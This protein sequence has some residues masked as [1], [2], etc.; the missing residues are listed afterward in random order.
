MCGSIAIT[1]MEKLDENYIC[2]CS[3]CRKNSGHLGQINSC[4][5]INKVMIDD[6]EK[7]LGEFLILNTSSGKPK[8]KEFCLRCG[9]TIRTRLDSLPGKCIVRLTLLDD[10]F[11]AFLPPEPLFLEEK[12]KFTKNIESEY[13]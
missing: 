8:H 10:G 11:P 9:C 12:L 13:F 5:D 3:D 2:H 4:Y 6:P 1:L 7:M